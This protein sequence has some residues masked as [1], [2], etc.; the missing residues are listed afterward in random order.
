MI[1]WNRIEFGE[2]DFS[3][4]S[5]FVAIVACI[6]QPSVIILSPMQFVLLLPPSSLS[7]GEVWEGWVMCENYDVLST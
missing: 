7:T 1:G 3:V 5:V 4:I 6:S 2:L